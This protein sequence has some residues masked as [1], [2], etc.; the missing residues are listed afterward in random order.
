MSQ[1]IISLGLGAGRE[2][3]GRGLLI[4]LPQVPLR[5]NNLL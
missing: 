2:E 3:E 5:G 4:G 1:Q